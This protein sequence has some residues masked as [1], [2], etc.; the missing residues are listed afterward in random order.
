V[1]HRLNIVSH[2][3][4]L[5]NRN[6]V[7]RVAKSPVRMKGLEDGNVVSGAG[8]RNEHDPAMQEEVSI[9][10]VPVEKLLKPLEKRQRIRL[11]DD[12]AGQRDHEVCPGHVAHVERDSRAHLWASAHQEPANALDLEFGDVP[13]GLKDT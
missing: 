11:L 2:A 12:L 1:I 9:L 8:I 13:P 5:F 10:S 3:T 7:H 4:K 6:H